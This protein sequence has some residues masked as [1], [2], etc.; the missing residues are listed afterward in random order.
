MAVFR[1]RMQS[2][3]NIKTQ[4]K[5]QAEMEF[6]M[7]QSRLNEEQARLEALIARKQSYTDEGLRMRE[8]DLDV[9]KLKENE[10]SI[11][12]MDDLI[13]GQ[14]ESIRLAERAVENARSRLTEAMKEV[15]AQERLREHAFEEF[16]EEVKHT[17]ARE[18]DELVSYRYGQ[19][20]TEED[21]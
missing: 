4:L 18:I 21:G 3:L 20:E 12:V 19:K 16:V 10:R 17:E 9:L 8:N 11:R 5:T 13:E 7:A 15:K 6:G 1:Y 14:R 2:L